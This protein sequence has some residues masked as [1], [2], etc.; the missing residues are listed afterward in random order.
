MNGDERWRLNVNG[1]E[2]GSRFQEEMIA[3]C[4][5]QEEA[6]KQMSEWRPAMKKMGFPK[7]QS[8]FR[9]FNFF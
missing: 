6:I 4:S 9:V 7:A 1:E 3:G 5:S 8:R 2:D